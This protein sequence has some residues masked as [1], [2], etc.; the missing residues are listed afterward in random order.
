MF[1]LS[2]GHLLILFI[3]ILIFGGKRL[4]ALGTA[5]GKGLSSF[6]KGLGKHDEPPSNR[7]DT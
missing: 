6:R 1:G 2:T 4:P 3:V 5:L 7:R